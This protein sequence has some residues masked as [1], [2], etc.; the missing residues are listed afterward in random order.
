[1]RIEITSITFLF[2]ISLVACDEKTQSI[3]SNSKVTDPICTSIATELSNALHLDA[4]DVSFIAEMT[5]RMQDEVHPKVNVHPDFNSAIINQGT[6]HVQFHFSVQNRDLCQF[7]AKADLLKD[8]TY[9]SGLWPVDLNLQ[10]FD[11]LQWDESKA[12]P[13]SIIQRLGIK[14]EPQTITRTPCLLVNEHQQ[15]EAGWQFRFVAEN[16]PYT[17]ISSE[18]KVY[19]ASEEFFDVVDG[20]SKIFAES[21][22]NST[23]M[24]LKTF[25]LKGLSEGGTLCNS[26]FKTLI[27]EPDIQVSNNTKK[28]FFYSINDNFFK[29]TSVFTNA[30]VYADW[31]LTHA[32]FLDT[33]DNTAKWPEKRIELWLSYDKVLDE[34]SF[35]INEAAYWPTGTLNRKSPAIRLGLGNEVALKNL[36]L[37]P[38]VVAHEIGHHIIYQSLKL[39]DKF[40]ESARLHEGLADFL[41]FSYTNNPCLGE[42]ICPKGSTTC[43]SPPPAAPS[44]LR[45]ANNTLTLEKITSELS[46]KNSAHKGSQLVSGFM[47]DL[48]KKIGLDTTTDIFLKSVHFF[49][50]S[51][52]YA[53]FL[54]SLM[55]ADLSLNKGKNTCTIEE[56]GIQRGFGDLM[57]NANMSCLNY[58]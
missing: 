2:F 11:D 15:V 29:E 8:K 32:A 20:E 24:V 40:S 7:Y 37:D 17:G 33:K 3:N 53:Q 39:I 54:D 4:E 56:V 21:P 44:C 10:N 18:N 34:K 57:K 6:K 27:N 46:L 23:N 1:M 51:C 14:G 41:V 12:N 52:N 25:P 28:Q 58:K 31:L 48:G 49:P 43:V 16:R 47:W 45:S 36:Q 22:M 9:L 13:R 38:E 50:R 42:N 26:L 19:Q 5:E 35:P 55:K 30:N